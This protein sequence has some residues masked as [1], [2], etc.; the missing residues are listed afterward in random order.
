MVDGAEGEVEC[1]SDGVMGEE[2]F[3]I[4]GM[5]SL[6]VAQNEDEDED[7]DKVCDKVSDEG[8]EQQ[9]RACWTNWLKRVSSPSW[10]D[11]TA[12]SKFQVTRAWAVCQR[13][14]AL[15]CLANSSR[16]TSPP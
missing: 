9:E 15:G 11:Q 6:S 13:R 1:W 4:G 7:S 16:P 10:E 12:M 3:W 14:A 5:A 2:G 8:W